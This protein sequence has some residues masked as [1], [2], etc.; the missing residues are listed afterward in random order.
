MR[1]AKYKYDSF[2]RMRNIIY[3]DGEVVRYGYT[4]GGLLK[5]VDGLKNGDNA[6]YLW[7]TGISGMDQINAGSVRAQVVFDDAVLYP[8]PYIVI[9]PKGYTKHYYAGT[10]RLATVI[11]G[12][13]LAGLTPNVITSFTQEEEPLRGQLNEYI[14]STDPFH[15]MNVLSSITQNED[16]MGYMRPELEYH[17]DSFVIDNLNFLAFSDILLGSIDQNLEINDIETDIYFY[18]G[19]HLG[20]A[21]WITDANG[22]AI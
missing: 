4:P 3:P 19:D 16:I 21:N 18:H 15:H 9:S 5:T 12:G 22:D 14:D 6:I 20:S 1:E 17:C 11:G 2:G 10:E 7:D 8:N 13:G